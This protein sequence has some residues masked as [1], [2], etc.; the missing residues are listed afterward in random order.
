MLC[1]GFC[2]YFRFILTCFLSEELQCL[3]VAGE[4]L[5]QGREMGGTGRWAGLADFSHY[6]GVSQR[7]EPAVASEK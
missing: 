3:C 1:Y 6:S 4:T 2:K 7:S 5:V